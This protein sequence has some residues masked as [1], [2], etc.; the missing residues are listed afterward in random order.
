MA[1]DMAAALMSDAEAAEVERLAA[2]RGRTAAESTALFLALAA[3][4][5]R[6]R[7]LTDAGWLNR[8]TV[9][10]LEQLHAA[11]AANK[12]D[13]AAIDAVIREAAR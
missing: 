12:T 2:K 7:H 8:L 13:T 6:A 1:D 10:Q 4:Q 11:L 3:G 5:V 9:P